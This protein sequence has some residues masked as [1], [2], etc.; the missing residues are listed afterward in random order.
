[1]FSNIINGQL[2]K[3]NFVILPKTKFCASF[4]NILWDEGIILG[5]SIISDSLK[6]FLKYKNGKPVITKLN[7]ISKPGK[8]IYYNV[9]QLWKINQTNGVFILSTTKGLM[10]LDNCKKYK[11]GG[12]PF[13]I[14]K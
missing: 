14:I 7:Y 3:K 4:L 2:T 8:K 13:I 11:I 6:I 12:K 9:K 10:S 5:Y 1:M